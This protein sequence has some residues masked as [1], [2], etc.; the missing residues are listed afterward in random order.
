M[1][2]LEMGIASLLS[3]GQVTGQRGGLKMERVGDEYLALRAFRWVSPFLWAWWILIRVF[4]RTL[5]FA[6]PTTLDNPVETVHLPPLVVLHHIIVLSPLRLPHEV[7]KWSEAEYVLWVQK[8][9]D[10]KEQLALLESAVNE[11]VGEKAGVVEED[12]EGDRGGEVGEELYV[13]LIREVL[14]HARHDDSSP[15]AA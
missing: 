9:V 11:Q 13:R 8:H 15:A 14:I 10:E 7:H 3:T 1:T 2:E 12:H 4:C 6:D 5:L